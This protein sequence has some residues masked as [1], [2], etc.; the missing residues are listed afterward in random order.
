MIEE[1][2]RKLAPR[3]P[4]T[5]KEVAFAD[6]TLT[7]AGDGWASSSPS[8]W[9][10]VKAGVLEFGWSNREASDLVWSSAACRS[11][12]SQPSPRECVVIQASSCQTAD[13]WR[14][15]RTTRWI[16]GH[17]DCRTLR[18]LAHH[19]TRR[20]RTAPVVVEAAQNEP[21]TRLGQAV[22]VLQ[23]LMLLVLVFLAPGSHSRATPVPRG[24]FNA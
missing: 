9:R 13:G 16:N 5:I 12:P 23:G 17:C 20:K 22:G 10:V 11:F 7:L 18:S 24:Y 4:L 6:P 15:S 8:A 21:E 14:S 1:L 2:R 3:M 19:P